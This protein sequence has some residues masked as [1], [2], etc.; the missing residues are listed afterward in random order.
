MPC[1]HVITICS[2]LWWLP[3]KVHEEASRKAAVSFPLCTDGEIL[4]QARGMEVRSSRSKLHFC[5][6][7][8]EFSPIRGGQGKS[9]SR[10]Q[11]QTLD[12]QDCS[13]K[14]VTWTSHLM[15]ALHND[16]DSCPN[17]SCKSRTTY[18][19][20]LLGTGHKEYSEYSSW[21][22]QVDAL[23]HYCSWVIQSF[24]ELDW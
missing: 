20:L 5:S 23:R 14:V 24:W 8:E 11:K 22:L 17:Y 1:N 3:Q 10:L 21:K 19:R 9:H 6:P 16:S 18:N 2:L 12:L 4:C 7:Q 13:R 15:T